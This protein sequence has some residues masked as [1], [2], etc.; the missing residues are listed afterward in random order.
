MEASWSKHF[1]LLARYNAWANDRLYGAVQQVAEAEYF[2]QRPSFFGS[3]HKTLSHVLV[4][5]RIWL[6]RITGQGSPHRSLDEV[7]YA[8]RRELTSARSREDARLEAVIA[9]LPDD[10]F[11]DT[12]S[13]RNMAG[14]EQ[15][16]PLLMV[17][18]HLF[19]HQT[20]HRGQVHQLLSAVSVAP[21]ALDLIY[22]VREPGVL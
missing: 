18:T 14:S 4:G 5:D 12:L 21:P 13:Y 22:F 19:N 17:L 15:T 11:A 3:I 1:R 8:G 6:G 10:C 2:A 9:A 7:P 16:T 20:H